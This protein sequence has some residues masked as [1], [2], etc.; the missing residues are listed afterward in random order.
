MVFQN[1]A[2]A[3]IHLDGNTYGHPVANISTYGERDATFQRE[4]EEYNKNHG[5]VIALENESLSGNNR[6]AV[7]GI[8]SNTQCQSLI[9]LADVSKGSG[10]IGQ[11]WRDRSILYIIYI[12]VSHHVINIWGYVL[13]PIIV[14]IYVVFK[15][16]LVF[17]CS[18]LI[19]IKLLV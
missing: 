13:I 8:L 1:N 16:I 10:V 4:L 14:M 12:G 17:V 11:G 3:K 15:S 5:I 7:D 9:K 19:L 6:V 18:E 2:G